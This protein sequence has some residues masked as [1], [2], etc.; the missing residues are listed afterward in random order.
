MLEF[1]QHKLQFLSA[2]F[3]FKLLSCIIK[4][5]K[6]RCLLNALIYIPYIETLIEAK[7]HHTVQKLVCYIFHRTEIFL[8]ANFNAL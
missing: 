8:L 3:S 7:L 4:T 1:K 2:I 5:E 6:N